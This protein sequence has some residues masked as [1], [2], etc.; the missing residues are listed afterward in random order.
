MLSFLRLWDLSV[1]FTPYFAPYGLFDPK[2]AYVYY[3]DASRPPG[4]FC[5]F[6]HILT[7]MGINYECADEYDRGRTGVVC[8]RNGGRG[9]AF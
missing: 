2:D 1:V 4:A 7:L 9:L 5:G 6:V 8:L 3:S